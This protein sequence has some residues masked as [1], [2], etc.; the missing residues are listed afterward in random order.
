LH[1]IDHAAGANSTRCG[2]RGSIPL[3]IRSAALLM[4]PSAGGCFGS[5]LDGLQFVFHFFIDSTSLFRFRALFPRVSL[6]HFD[7]SLPS[8]AFLLRFW[9]CFGLLSRWLNSE[10]DQ[11]FLNPLADQRPTERSVRHERV[12]VRRAGMPDH[13][14]ANGLLSGET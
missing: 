9:H 7:V 11:I 4:N 5:G 2:T 6:D 12:C 1:W 13:S 14:Q 8:A 3:D 10:D